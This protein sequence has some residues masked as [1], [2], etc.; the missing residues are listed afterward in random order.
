MF[1]TSNGI[2]P[3]AKNLHPIAFS[4]QVNALFGRQLMTPKGEDYKIITDH[5]KLLKEISK[6]TFQDAKI[7]SEDCVIIKHNKPYV[8]NNQPLAS[9]VAIL[10]L[11]K[12]HQVCF[13]YD[14]VMKTFYHPGKSEVTL[15]T[16]DTGT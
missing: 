11:S 9:G 7:L 6:P 10:D 13:W 2:K 12:Y 1:L 4:L 5:K 3:L 16:S 14:Q 8:Y 15:H